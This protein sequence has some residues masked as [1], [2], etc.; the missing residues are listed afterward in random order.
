MLIIRSFQSETI[1]GVQLSSTST[2]EFNNM[3]RSKSYANAVASMAN[4]EIQ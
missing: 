3:M 2:K 4:M 1:K